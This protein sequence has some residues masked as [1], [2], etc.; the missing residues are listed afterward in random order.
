VETEAQRQFL[1]RHGCSTYQGFLFSEPVDVAQF[2][3]LLP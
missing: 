3:R 2:E 1:E